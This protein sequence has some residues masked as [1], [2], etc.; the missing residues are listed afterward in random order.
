MVAA[1]VKDHLSPKVTRVGTAA[2]RRKKWY[3]TFYGYVDLNKDL[4]KPRKDQIR[5]GGNH[6]IPSG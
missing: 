5:S 3:D 6:L 2:Q 1:K 4:K